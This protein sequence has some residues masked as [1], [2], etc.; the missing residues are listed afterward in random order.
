MVTVLRVRQQGVGSGSGLAGIGRCVVTHEG[1]VNGLHHVIT[2]AK[3]EG[4]KTLPLVRTIHSAV[5]AW[6]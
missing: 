2:D 4:P 3:K 5:S 1:P 6:N